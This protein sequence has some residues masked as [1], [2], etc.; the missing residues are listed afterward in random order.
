MKSLYS[1]LAPWWP[2]PRWS[3][4]GRRFSFHTWW[5]IVTC[6]WGDSHHFQEWGFFELLK[7]VLGFF[8]ILNSG[9]GEIYIKARHV[10]L[11]R[12]ESQKENWDPVSPSLDQHIWGPRGVTD[13]SNR[14]LNLPRT[15]FLSPESSWSPTAFVL[16]YRHRKWSFSTFMYV[17]YVFCSQSRG[18]VCCQNFLMNV[19]QGYSKIRPI[20][21]DI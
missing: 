9:C 17:K 6:C 16:E 12:P 5:V 15:A 18:R 8:Q 3:P 7:V 20:L 11:Q 1:P 21:G 10:I 2:L 19:L 13:H 14:Y 4:R